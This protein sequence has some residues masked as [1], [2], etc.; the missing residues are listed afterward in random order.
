MEVA[1][2]EVEVEVEENREVIIERLLAK[3][4]LDYRCCGHG[5]KAQGLEN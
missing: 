5:G 4:E 2:V 3:A 1:A